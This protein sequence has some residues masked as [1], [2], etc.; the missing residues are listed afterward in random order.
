MLGK[1]NAEVKIS[2]LLGQGAEINGDFNATGSARL[3][4]KVNGNVS[5]S[6]TLILGAGGVVNGDVTADTVVIGGEIVGNVNAPTKTELT[7]TARVLG[8]I[9]TSVIVID[10][11]AVFQGRCDMNQE[12]PDRKARSNA[13]KAIRAGRKTAK[14]AIA[15]AL[16]EVEEEAMKDEQFGVTENAEVSGQEPA[17]GQSSE[18]ESSSQGF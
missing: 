1:K 2:T 9:T 15:E 17:F 16:K 12:V 8:D 6:G 7:G 3:D 18:Q 4:G 11:H 14:A 13:A 10:E 5:V